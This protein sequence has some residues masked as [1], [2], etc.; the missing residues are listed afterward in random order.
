MIT[1]LHNSN[2]P[3]VQ[4]N[5]LGEILAKEKFLL[6]G[7]VV[8]KDMKIEEDTWFTILNS[9]QL[10]LLRDCLRINRLQFGADMRLAS[11]LV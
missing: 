9:K 10:D 2:K 11:A 8:G 1:D 3:F 6:L 4:I 5:L 7:F